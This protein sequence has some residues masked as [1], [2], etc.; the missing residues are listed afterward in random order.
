MKRIMHPAQSLL[1]MAVLLT[2]PAALADEPWALVAARGVAPDGSLRGEVAVVIDDGRITGVVAP[3]QLES[4]IR[5]VEYDGAVISPGLIDLHSQLGVDRR[6]VERISPTDSAI[7]VVEGVDAR[8]S[9]MRAAVE[10]GITAALITPYA[11]ST[12]C[13]VGAAI[14]TWSTDG[15]VEVLAADGPLV[16]GLGPAT[17]DPNG[18]PTSRAGA[19]F[20]LREALAG[21]DARLNSAT[22]GELPML[23]DC[24][25]AQ[26]VDAALRVL[27]R[28][29]VTPIIYAAAESADAAEVIGAAEAAAIV[30]PYSFSTSARELSGAG[31]LHEAGARIGFR[32]GAPSV[33]SARLRETAVLAV[34][35]GLDADAAR[36]G[37][38]SGAA[39]IAGI[40]DRVG[41]IRR[42]LDADLVIF[43]D[44]PL[45]LNARV[46]AVYSRGELVYASHSTNGGSHASM[47]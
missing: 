14:R 38:T 16:I 46:L 1:T 34:Q 18:E 28:H 40:G 8:S 35:G 24:A 3:D 36:R 32:S 47:E 25:Q 2:A 41:A 43:S 12:V 27:G 13:G 44:D 5:R 23:V 39:A 9:D 33:H 6:P 19:L 30:G 42:G 7:R 31:A 4:S 20:L 29:G 17:W 37:L 26:D 45:R 22:G 11:R 15:A 10:A 21:D